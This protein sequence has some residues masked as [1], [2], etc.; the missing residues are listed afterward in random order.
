MYWKVF[1]Y[2]V[3]AGFCLAIL[4][5]LNQHLFY[6]LFAA[7]VMYLLNDIAISFKNIAQNITK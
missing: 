5:Y 6:G 2:Y 4:H 1:S 7:V 3:A